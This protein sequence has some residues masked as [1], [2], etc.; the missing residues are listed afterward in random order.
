MIPIGYM[1]ILM[2]HKDQINPPDCVDMEEALDMR[3]QDKSL[4][5]ISFL[6]HDLKPNR[7]FHECIDMY[8]RI[9]FIGVLPLLSSID[10]FQNDISIRAYIGIYL[11]LISAIYFREVA[12]YRVEFTNVLATIAQYQIL[13]VFLAALMIQT[14]TFETFG[15]NDFF[16]GM[17]LLTANSTV[18]VM[19][20]YVGYRK[21]L[22]EQ[23]DKLKVKQNI[24][25][26]EWAAHFSDNKFATTFQSVIETSLSS[27]HV[28][29]FHYTSLKAAKKWVKTG[30]PALEEHEGIVFSLRGPHELRQGVS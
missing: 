17:I 20:I 12:P 21:F 10:A 15:V 4:H 9:M 24:V 30:I 19:A 1:M 16:L 7:W 3:D 28:M 26:I 27:S 29:V 5:S 23:A 14:G 8:R 11:S 2:Y 25:K 13:T 18:L 6:F 22:Q